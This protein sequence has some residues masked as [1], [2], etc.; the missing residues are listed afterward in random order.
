VRL[1]KKKPPPV[2]AG[3]DAWMTN[4]ISVSIYP[5]NEVRAIIR[6]ERGVRPY[7]DESWSEEA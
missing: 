4:S 1:S 7:F 3:K 5:N 6:R 2:A